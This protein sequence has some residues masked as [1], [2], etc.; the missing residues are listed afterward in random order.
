VLLP[1]VII[2]LWFFF[3][4]P[5]EGI[6]LIAALLFLITAWHLIFAHRAA[7][8]LRRAGTA[9]CDIPGRDLPATVRAMWVLFR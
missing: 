1:V 9:A 2:W 3:R 5:F 6:S 7:A 8:I 4:R